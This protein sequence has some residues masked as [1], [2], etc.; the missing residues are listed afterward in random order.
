MPAFHGSGSEGWGEV[1]VPIPDPISVD[2]TASGFD[3]ADDALQIISDCSAV[4][5]PIGADSVEGTVL[6]F[7]RIPIT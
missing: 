5:A 4:V 6:N 1:C 2:V 7:W 3:E